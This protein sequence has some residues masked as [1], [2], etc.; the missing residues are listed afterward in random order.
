[1][2]KKKLL[3]ID[4]HALLHRAYH[5][6]PNLIN[7]KGEPV[8]A[9]Y[10]FA[11]ILINILKQINPDY[12]VACFDLA[13]PTLRHEKFPAYKAQRPKVPDDLIQQFKLIKRFLKNLKIPILEK[14]GYEADDAIGTVV[15]EMT[16]KHPDIEN[17]VLTGDL[18]TLQLINS[19][20]KIL[21]PR[22]GLSD[23]V[24]YNAQKLKEKFPG[25]TPK[26][27]IEYKGLK[28]DPS[29]NIPGV[30]GIGD[31]TAI[32]LLNMFGNL[33]NLYKAI[34]DKKKLKRLVSQKI[35]RPGLVKKLQEYKDQA[36]FSREL[37]TIYRNVPIKFKLKDAK[38]DPDP[39]SIENALLDFGLRSLVRR[40]KALSEGKELPKREYQ[41][42]T[43]APQKDNTKPGA[44]NKEKSVKNKQPSKAQKTL[45]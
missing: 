37:A 27:I 35:L 24:L 34:E 26:Q 29:D 6:L 21:T 20:T 32:R 30:P 18:D 22:R 39:V 41:K 17:I 40:F 44:H 38:W 8:G 15:T 23:P 28:G 36:F 45:F 25:L 33:E 1:M 10:G 12:I 3:I 7:S 9:I 4:S 19:H 16:K 31:K 14:A 11:S 13:K 5:A 43:K 2:N 42:N